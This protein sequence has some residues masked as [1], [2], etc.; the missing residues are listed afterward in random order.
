M[1]TQK[2]AETGDSPS[3]ATR[4][5]RS[6]GVVAHPERAPKHERAQ[7]LVQRPRRH[8]GTVQFHSSTNHSIAV[9]RELP[10]WV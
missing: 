8:K 2:F 4:A 3:A 10:A 7:A 6:G 9:A 1:L 5:A